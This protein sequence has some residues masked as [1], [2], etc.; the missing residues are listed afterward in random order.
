[1][2]MILNKESVFNHIKNSTNAQFVCKNYLKLNSILKEAKQ[3]NKTSID[4]VLEINEL[5]NEFKPYIDQKIMEENE[6][7]LYNLLRNTSA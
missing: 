6:E 5:M 7:E 4:S 1:M 2:N 3:N